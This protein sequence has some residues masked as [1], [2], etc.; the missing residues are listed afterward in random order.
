MTTRVDAVIVGAGPAGAACA[1]HLARRGVRT[2]VVEK[3][4]YPRF[5]IGES[6]TGESGNLLRR[7]GLEDS[8]E[9][10]PYVR[11]HGVNTFGPAGQESWHVPVMA[12]DEAGGLVASHT[13]QVRR[14]RFDA[15]LM[16]A[17]REQ[18]VEVVRGEATTPLRGADGAVRGV[19]IRRDDGR[20]AS[21]EAEVTVDGSGLGTFLART[22]VTGPKYMGSYDRQVAFFTHVTGAR[23]WDDPSQSITT[24]NTL[25]FYQ[26][27]FHWAWLI[28]IDDEV[29]S[30]GVV[31][32]GDYYRS[33]NESREQFLRRELRELNPGLAE[34]MEEA[35]MVEPV[36]AI[37]NYS[38]QVQGFCGPGFLCV[39]D[40]H[41]FVDPIFSF[42]VNVAL[43]EAELAG[44]AVERYLAGEK[45]D[46]PNPFRDHLVA[47]EHAIDILE[48]TVDLFWE[49]PLAFAYY[50]HRKYRDELID[51]FAGRIYTGTT[52]LA[53]EVFRRGLG[54]ER[55]YD[56]AALVSLPAGSRY[57]PD[58]AEIWER[59]P[60]G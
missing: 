21:I 30:V 19:R 22:G 45:R 52:N 17:V 27:K 46:R 47:A 20:E 1:I 33:R 37:V 4:E 26:Q 8:L 56:D 53:H 24:G 2:L 59:K 14:S 43:Q 36:R 28:P 31:V 5:H 35:T 16:D 29:V 49:Q 60:V 44:A 7:L 15:G 6:L 12:R 48:D 39:G 34:R 51:T 40:A 54:R 10:G 11:K 9:T 25:I 58:R 41:R 55:R 57:Q 38:Y 13:W 42:G 18:G 50:V 32:P 3:D 23:L